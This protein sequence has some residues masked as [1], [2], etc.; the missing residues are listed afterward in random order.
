MFARPR[1]KPHL[2]VEALPGEGLVVLSETENVILSE[3]LYATIAPHLDGSHSADAIVAALTGQADPSEVHRVLEH[4]ERLGLLAEAFAD[5]ATGEVSFW[6]SCDVDPAVVRRRLM[7]SRVA[8]DAVGEVELAPLVE[9]LRVVGVRTSEDAPRRVVVTDDY[10]R[11]ELGR[12]NERA[13]GAGREW[14]LVKLHG[15]VV[16]L[17]PVFRPGLGACWECLAERLRANRDAE[18]F[19]VRRHRRA[20]PLAVGR[21]V[22]TEASQQLAARIAA[23]ATAGW[24]ACDA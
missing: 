14:L 1:F 12:Y 5:E 6:A 19:L 2:H 18:S 15:C 3:P 11:G 10:L 16:W 24:L 22:T 13:I 9:A 8:L 4:L 20:E 21:A 7:E 17:G 23:F